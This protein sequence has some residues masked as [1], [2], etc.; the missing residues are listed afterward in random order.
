MQE[1]NFGAIS[2][3]VITEA[4]GLKCLSQGETLERK[5]VGQEKSSNQG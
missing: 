3:E 2:T 5:T 1:N 4:T